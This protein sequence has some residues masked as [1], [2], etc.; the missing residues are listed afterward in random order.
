MVICFHELGQKREGLLPFSSLGLV[1][2]F[3]FV[4]G[5]WLFVFHEVGQKREGL[6]TFSS[7]GV[8]DF[9]CL[10]VFMSVRTRGCR[11]ILG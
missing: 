9:S 1:I 6:L 7:L 3:V 2:S 5:S 10:F 4:L 8:G 11:C